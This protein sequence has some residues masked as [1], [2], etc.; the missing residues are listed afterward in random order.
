MSRSG[1]RGWTLAPLVALVCG[2]GVAVT[3]FGIVRHVAS[4]DESE[5]LNQRAAEVRATL[6]TSTATANASLGIL[7]AFANPQSQGDPDGFERAAGIVLTKGVKTVGLV[8][9]DGSTLR[10]SASVGAGPSAGDVLTG[11]RDAVVRRAMSA[12]MLASAVF[13]DGAETRLVFAVPTALGGAVVYQESVL[14]PNRP[15]PVTKD[16][17]YHELRVTLYAGPRPDA[18]HLILS[19]ESVPLLSGETVTLSFPVGAD[20]WTLMVSSRGP[21]AGGFAGWAP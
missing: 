8:N 12:G 6:L 10:V 9:A 3:A 21:L 13:R 7:G 4:H 16:S 20:T 14:D 15:I 1:R 5:L 2:L 17:P 19:T 18:A 11:D